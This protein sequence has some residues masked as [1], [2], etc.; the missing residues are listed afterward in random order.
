VTAP[1]VNFPSIGKARSGKGARTRKQMLAE[2]RRRYDPRL[3][4]EQAAAF[5]DS[6]EAAARHSRQRGGQ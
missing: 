1:A 2:R 6:I 4:A 3:T 5:A